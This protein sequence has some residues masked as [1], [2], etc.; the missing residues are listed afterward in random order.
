MDTYA[1]DSSFRWPYSL[2]SSTYVHIIFVVA[3]WRTE[4]PD[5]A[6]REDVAEVM[7]VMFIQLPAFSGAVKAASD[8]GSMIVGGSEMYLDNFCF[9]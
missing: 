9:N 3:V 7:L 4:E 8:I 6:A 5:S 2:S 1:V